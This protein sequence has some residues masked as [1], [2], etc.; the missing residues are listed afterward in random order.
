MPGEK[1]LEGVMVD[2]F[3]KEEAEKER[4]ENEFVE[5]ELKKI[6]S[7]FISFSHDE[8]YFLNKGIEEE[9]KFIRKCYFRIRKVQKKYN[10]DYNDFRVREIENEIFNHDSIRV[11]FI[12]R[13]NKL[14]Y[15][16][17]NLDL[18][19][20]CEDVESAWEEEIKK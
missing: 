1:G 3:N 20:V 12:K 2:L 9:D 14:E 8:I 16:N 18:K 19:N 15:E 4:E 6:R 10:C 17:D 11:K 13:R 5:N 7:K